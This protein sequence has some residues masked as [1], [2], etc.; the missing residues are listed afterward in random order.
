M[1]YWALVGLST[2]VKA[3]APKE[4]IDRIA[5]V[6]ENDPSPVNRITA[7]RVLCQWGGQGRGTPLLLAAL[8][9]G[10]PS[11]RLHAALALDALPRD[12]LRPHLPA[13]Q[14]VAASAPE[15]PQRVL[16]HMIR[17]IEARK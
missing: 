13:L 9:G 10:P 16:A 4:R 2:A 3:N 14:A 8:D 11:L 5:I 17:K 7:A 1:R 12:N 6:M 15:Y